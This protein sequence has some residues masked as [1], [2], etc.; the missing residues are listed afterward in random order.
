M[1]LT[2]KQRRYLRSLA[3]HRNPVAMIGAA[4]LTP[5]VVNEIDQ[6]LKRHELIKIKIN[7]PSKSPRKEIIVEICEQTGC[8]WVQDIGHITIVYRA[9]KNP[10]IIF[11]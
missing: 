7:R 9:K 10:E 11:P 4:G 2:P 8:Q 5:A 6:C 1:H 3:H